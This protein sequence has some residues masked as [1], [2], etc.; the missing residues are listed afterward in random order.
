MVSEHGYNSG[1]SSLIAIDRAYEIVPS[2][3]Q[4]RSA[5]LFFC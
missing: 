1:V 2:S 4:K 5:F 3:Y